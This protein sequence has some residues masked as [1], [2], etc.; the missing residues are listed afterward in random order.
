MKEK[1]IQST[2][3]LN[4]KDHD[5]LVHQ[6]RQLNLNHADF[7]RELIRKNKFEDIKKTNEYLQELRFLTRNLSNNINQI[8]KKINSNIILD[9]LEEVKTIKEEVN[10]VWQLLKS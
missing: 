4:Q 3:R 5:M 6:A 9:E 10:K 7:F 8:A 1:I 2:L